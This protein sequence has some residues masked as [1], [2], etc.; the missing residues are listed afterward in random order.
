LLL[1]HELRNTVSFLDGVIS[2]IDLTLDAKLGDVLV[3]L[4]MPSAWNA[5][6]LQRYDLP[7][8]IMEETFVVLLAYDT[9]PLKVTVTGLCTFGFLAR[10]TPYTR[11]VLSQVRDS[12][13]I[14]NVA[15]A[16]LMRMALTGSCA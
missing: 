12:G 8:K 5:V 14:L 15:R 1:N 3:T 4:G 6:T 9:Y 16:P 13:D 2:R 11:I 7:G 10:E